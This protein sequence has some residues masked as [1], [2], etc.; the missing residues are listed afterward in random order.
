MDKQNISILPKG[1]SV[2]E[3]Y[4]VMLFIK[5]GD[6]ANTY[7]VKGKDG[8]IYF[9]KLFNLN[10]IH[11]SS[12]DDDKN[13]SE[14]EI[15]KSL[16]HPNIISYVD[17][18]ELIFNDKKYAYLVLNFISGET[19]TESIRRKPFE[20]LYDIKQ[21]ISAVL[22][23][24]K[25]LHSQPEPIIHND[26]TPQNIMI[27]LSGKIPKAIIIDFGYARS[28]FKSSKSFSTNGLNLNYVATECFNN[29][30]S[31]QSDLY[32]IG[33]IL[34]QLIYNSI[35]WF[36]DV[37]SYNSNNR[38]ELIIASRS[39]PLILPEKPNN[40]FDFDESILKVVKKA[41]NQDPDKR[42]QTADEF[43]KA[44]N[45]EIEVEE[46]GNLQLSSNDFEEKKKA[47]KKKLGKGFD[48]IAGMKDLKEQLQL[49]V[50]DALN[51][52]EEYAKYGVTIPN[53]MLLY[54]PPGCGKT[55]FAKHFAEEVGFNFVLAT[56][57]T[58]KSKYVNATQENILNMFKEAE[59][60][61]P[62]IIFIDEINEL[63]PNRE[64]D[65]HEMSKSAVNEMLA[66]M[67]RTGE[68][69]IFIIGATNFPEMID[70]AILRAGRLDKKFYLPPP[71]LDARKSM[72]EMYL[73]HRP[74]D[75]GIDYDML[76]GLTENYVSSDIEYLVN[77]A[78]RKALKLK[79]RI[80]MEILESVIK[81]TKPSVPLSELEK[82]EKVRLKMNSENNDIKSERPRIGF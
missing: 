51:N 21:I 74:L 35:P 50:I 29:F 47:V 52:P 41:L 26:L 39:K 38:E 19:L 63:L 3:K 25:Y 82:Y 15:S 11:H 54:G 64:S 59:K 22:N 17:N 75:F 18:G 53:G 37:S 61:A 32:S 79:S 16:I 44:L 2:N 80:N 66:Q 33:T 76:S 78:S 65:V 23:G 56:P 13:I 72:F 42:F 36:R 58:L 62:T 6:Y 55:F 34:Y 46:V 9:L 77:E 12:L 20:S 49:D 60:N 73:N 27:D 8:K 81:S 10:R 30:Y 43:I 1:F 40:L 7:R 70:P 57:S 45:G 69:G 24:I 48:A 31:P 4:S 71:D 5:Q 14:I 28:Y 68:K 67:D